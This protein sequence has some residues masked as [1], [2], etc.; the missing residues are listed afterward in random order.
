[1]EELATK[2]RDKV[3]DVLAERLT[4]ERSGVKPD[5]VIGDITEI[6]GT[7]AGSR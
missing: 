2:N 7:V 6:I 3:I 4:F 1:M 5:Y